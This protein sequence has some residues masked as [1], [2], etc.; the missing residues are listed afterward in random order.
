MSKTARNSIKLSS[1]T[2]VSRFLGL[3]RD[4]YQAVFFG[5]G[6]VATAWEIAFMLPNM[7]R[8]LLAEGVLSQAFIPI[9]SEAWKKSEDEARRVA[10]VI[11]GFLFF[12]LLGIVFLGIILFP[13][14]LPLYTG[15]SGDRAELLIYLS[16]VMFVF[17]LTVSL[18]AILTGMANT[19]QHFSF[20][21]ISP[22]ILNL[23]FI[24]SFWVLI[25]FDFTS[26]TNARYLAWGVVIGGFAQL[27]TQIYYVRKKGWWPALT[28]T[29]NDPA[30][31]KI[32][33]RMA[34]AILGASLFQLNQ[35]MDIAIASYMIPAEAGA[36]PA[37]RYAHRLIQLPTGI[38]GVALSTAIL[39]TLVHSIRSD[40]GE[41]NAGELMNAIS[42]SLFLTVPA[43]IGLYL[44]GPEIINLLFY[45]GAWDLKSSA[46][47]W[48]ALQFYCIGIPFY[49]ANK[50]IT[51]TYYAY[52]DTRTPMNIMIKVVIL[53]FA[54]NLALVPIFMQGGLALA[55]SITSIVNGGWLM[56]SLRKKTGNF[57]YGRFFD[58]LK[59]QFPVWICLILFLLALNSFFASASERAGITVSGWLDGKNIPRY[60]ALVR[61]SAGIA[62]AA[63]IVI[64]M[65]ILL[66][67][68]EIN[69]FKDIIN[70]RRAGPKS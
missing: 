70:S 43:G 50:I 27:G 28:V 40:K 69:V 23:V 46:A 15:Q 49:S 12:V 31:K 36:V 26:E 54:L 7:L 22:I 57:P 55:T 48:A 63:V 39:P 24:I 58:S 47:T 68:R 35:L 2:I 3:L 8:N 59:K 30:L 66:R 61:V 21:A 17:I 14:L 29:W 65:S 42:F 19:H 52:Q 13:Y 33:S 11:L 4:H 64:S 44:M 37:L 45:G 9:Y 34:P 60:T 62:G 41:E 38:I 1:F 51:S 53:N 5:T 32:F 25:P 20:P 67:L 16:R 10:G 18:T 6:V 56:F